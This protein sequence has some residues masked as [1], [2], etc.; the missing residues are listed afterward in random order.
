MAEK[1]ASS[2]AP[3]SQATLPKTSPT[4]QARWTRVSTGLG[5]VTSPFTRA[6]WTDVSTSLA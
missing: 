3:Q 2:C 5:P 1:A 6:T 4:G